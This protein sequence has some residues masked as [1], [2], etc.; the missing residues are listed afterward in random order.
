MLCGR[1]SCSATSLFFLSKMG[2]VRLCLH[3][4]NRLQ[5]SLGLHCPFGST[6]SSLSTTLLIP[7]LFMYRIVFIKFLS[8]TSSQLCGS[9]FSLF[10]F[11]QCCVPVDHLFTSH[12]AP[13]FPHDFLKL[14]CGHLATIR[15]TTGTPLFDPAS[16]SGGSRVASLCSQ[17]RYDSHSALFLLHPALACL[18]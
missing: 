9:T 11:V 17:Q 12:S 16:D 3:A 13:I 8:Q 2:S 14:R 4:W 7:R 1:S 15:M 5:E 10:Q 6:L 18:S